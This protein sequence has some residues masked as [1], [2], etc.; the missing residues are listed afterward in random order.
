MA[1]NHPKTTTEKPNGP[2]SPGWYAVYTRYKCEKQVARDLVKKG[3]TTWV[4]L[5]QKVRRYGARRRVSEIPLIHCYVFV[6]MQPD[7]KNRVLQTAN[8]QSFLLNGRD[9]IRIPEEEIDWLRRIVGEKS[10]VETR[11]EDLCEGM[12]VEVAEG[13]LAGIRGKLLHREGKSR[14]LVELKTI[15][16]QLQ[17]AI[18]TGI[19]NNVNPEPKAV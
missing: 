18:D 17:M 16:Y 7:Q 10:Q 19:L 11:R 6:R 8:V 4:P 5:R 14:F 9:L 15:G 12:E 1:E 13:P 2:D 3:I